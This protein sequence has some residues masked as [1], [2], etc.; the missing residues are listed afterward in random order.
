[1]LA[2][3]CLVSRLGRLFE[4]Y[5]VQVLP[6]LLAAFGDGSADV[7][8]AAD[9]AARALMAALSAS[10]VKLVL[11]ALLRGLDDGAAW[12]T[13]QGSA[14][15]LGAMAHCAP[16]Q[17]GSC[18]PSVVP[19]LTSALGDPHPKVQAAA[20]DAL[21]QVGS[22]VRNPELQALAP[23]LLAALADPAGAATRACLDALLDTAFVSAVDAAS[24][25]LVA[26][27]VHRGLRERSGEA[28]RRAA[29]IVG[30][31]ATLVGDCKVRLFFFHFF[32]FVLFF[33]RAKGA[34]VARGDDDAFF[35]FPPEAMSLPLGG[36]GIA[37]RTSKKA[38]HQSSK[39]SDRGRACFSPWFLFFHRSPRTNATNTTP[40]KTI[41]PAPLT[42]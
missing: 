42:K 7:R 20:R 21:K 17:L 30:S 31:M 39:F 14:Q 38:K 41:Q 4:P 18:L 29:R 16:R 19:R 6:L 25:A 32:F 37:L 40:Q 35:S 11:P 34:H 2:L 33:R 5:V 36:G 23:S 24:L 28:K 27:V 10:G 15:M 26:P 9:D 22:V 13:K 12:R 3:E 8:A 1:M